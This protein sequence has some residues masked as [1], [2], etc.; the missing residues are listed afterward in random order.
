[1]EEEGVSIMSRNFAQ[2][3][4]SVCLLCYGGVII[5]IK[6]LL[7]ALCKSDWE[8]VRERKGRKW[9]TPKAGHIGGT[10]AL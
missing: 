4:G 2:M 1:M 6:L 3:D 9:S 8:T 10:Q 5:G 7:K